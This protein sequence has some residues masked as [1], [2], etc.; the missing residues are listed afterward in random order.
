MIRKTA[1]ILSKW[2]LKAGAISEVDLGLYEY[3]IYSFLFTLIPLF[4]VI[5]LSF[6][7]HITFEG[8]LFIIPFIILR[9]FTGGFHFSSALLCTLV[10]IVVLSAFLLGIKVLIILS[11][12][13]PAYVTVYLSLIP[14]ITLSPIDSMNRRLTHKEKRVFRKIAICLGIFFAALFT[15][16]MLL[17]ISRVA[18]PIGAGIVL[19]AL[20]QLPCLLKLRETISHK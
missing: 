2:L 1:N 19:T 9:K 14:I 13:I 8:I 17:G 6:P 15:L 12:S 5:L 4:A 10:S 3:G 11:P 7:F 20:L 16:L 18:I